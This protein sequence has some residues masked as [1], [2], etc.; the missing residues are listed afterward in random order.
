MKTSI[1][2]HGLTKTLMRYLYQKL[3][4]LCNF[5]ICLVKASNGAPYSWPDVQG[6]EK[7]VVDEQ[8]FL[9]KLAP[10]LNPS[11]TETLFAR[12]DH[13][14]ASIFKDQ[15]VGHTFYSC[16]DT[17]IKPGLLFRVPEGYVYSFKAFTSKAHRGRRLE[18]DRWKAAR[19]HRIEQQGTDLRTIFYVN[20]T[21]LES[22]A[23]DQLANSVTLGYSAYVI[24]FGRPFVYNSKTCR[25]HQAGFA[26]AEVTDS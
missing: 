9:S 12:G 7:R 4:R 24:L 26:A 19:A 10:D 1:Q 25:A 22:L 20:V 18:P 5:E 23:A 15:V 3:N 21:N 17:A 2:R 11:G 14:A 16:Q 13:C 8:E 6:Y